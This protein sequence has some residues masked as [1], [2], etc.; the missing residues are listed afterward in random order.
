MTNL[1]RALVAPAA[2]VL[3]LTAAGGALTAVAAPAA[4]ASCESYPQYEVSAQTATLRT[5]PGGAGSTIATL[6]HGHKF[7][8]R[9]DG[10]YDAWLFGYAEG[11][12]YGWSLK[13]GLTYTRPVTICH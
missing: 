3:T 9:G 2:A 13:S 1:R 4:A 7:N 12:G 8:S 6:E 5:D 11:V 10:G